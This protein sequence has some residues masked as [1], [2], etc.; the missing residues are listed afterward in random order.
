[1]SEYRVDRQR[2]AELTLF[3]QMGNISSEVGR[4][5]NAK[6]AGKE[7]RM[8]GA[9]DRAVDLFDATAEVWAS[10]KSPRAREV[11]RA[12]DQFLGLFFDPSGGTDEAGIERYFMQYAQAACTSS[13]EY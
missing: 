10:R 11:L 1:M 4:A 5:I 13:S 8:N 7:A 2:W 9:I 3:E 12:K 6:R